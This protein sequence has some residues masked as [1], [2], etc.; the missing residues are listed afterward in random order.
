MSFTTDVRSE[1]AVVLPK[2]EHCLKAELAAFLAESG[3][4]EPDR[5]LF[6]KECCKKAFLRGAFLAAGSFSDPAKSYNLEFTLQRRSTADLVVSL[7]SAFEIRGKTVE[8]NGRFVV[9][10]KDGDQISDF[11]AVVQASKTLLAYENARV[12]KDVRNS[13]NRRVNCEVANTGKTVTAGISMI[14][15]IEKI[16][17]TRGLD[18]LPEVLRET[19]RLRMEYPSASLKE[20]GELMDPPVG[21]SGVNHRLRR[22]KE[23][24]EEGQK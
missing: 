3:G 11:L 23:I 13:V 1:I 15:D 17:L 20:L 18:S 22:L 5:S 4:E 21:K 19:A 12:I 7:L 14:H 24:A 2:E 9:Y 8:R 16:E 10:L 6:S